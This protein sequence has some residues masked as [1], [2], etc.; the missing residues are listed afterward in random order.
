VV[1]DVCIW[2]SIIDFLLVV[3]SV[4]I[5]IIVLCIVDTIV[6]VIL[7]VGILIVRNTIVVIVEV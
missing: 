7:G 3:N 6:I 5:V 1:V 4:S 2:I